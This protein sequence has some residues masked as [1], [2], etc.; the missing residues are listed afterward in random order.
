MLKS[1]S[2]LVAGIE[3]SIEPFVVTF[4]LVEFF[5]PLNPAL[6]QWSGVKFCVYQHFRVC[7]LVW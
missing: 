5:T 6:H 3:P 7:Q 2:K 1:S 4:L